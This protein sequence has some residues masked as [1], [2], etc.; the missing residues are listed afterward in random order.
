MNSEIRYDVTEDVV[1]IQAGGTTERRTLPK[2]SVE[3]H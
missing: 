3:F 2:G 1:H